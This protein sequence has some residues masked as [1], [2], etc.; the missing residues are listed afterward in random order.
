M[1]GY[2][3][4]LPALT[5]VKNGMRNYLAGYPNDDITKSEHILPAQTLFWEVPE[6]HTS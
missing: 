1:I 3:G 5:I 2:I 6:D 4:E